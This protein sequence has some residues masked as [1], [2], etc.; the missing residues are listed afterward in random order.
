MTPRVALRAAT[1][2]I[3]ISCSAS[4]T[5]AQLDAA[6]HEPAAGRPAPSFGEDPLWDDGQAELSRYAAEE[7]VEGENR[8]FTAWSI[9]VAE[10]FDPAQMV[11]ADAWAPAHV[12]V[13]KCNWFLTIPTGVY[14]YQQMASLFVRR[15]DGLVVKAAFSSQEW[16]GT[17]FAEW[18]R[19]QSGLQV[20][21]YW[22]GEGDRRHELPELGANALFHEQLPLWIRGRRPE[23][24]R[25]EPITLVA[26][27]LGAARC[28]A[29]RL[30]PAA[31]AFDGPKEDAAGR[32]LEARLIV[33]KREETFVLAP[34]FPHLLQEWRRADGTTWKLEKSVRLDYWKFSRNEFADLLK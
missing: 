16:C 22:D 1:F 8:R 9:V 11:K 21:S 32:R 31:V 29:P 24:T 5:G 7:M 34:E 26:K 2:A 15:S 10:H 17:T 28:P 14:S 30:V 3:G 27:R 25:S 12:P 23:R 20:H 4:P 18:R 13:L 33:D 19:D 6:Q